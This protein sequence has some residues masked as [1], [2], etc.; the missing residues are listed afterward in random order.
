ML[1]FTKHQWKS[2]LWKA[3]LKVAGSWYISDPYGIG[4]NSSFV[5]HIR[6][7]VMDDMEPE[8]GEKGSRNFCTYGIV[9]YKKTTLKDT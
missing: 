6:K 4:I 7:G 9:H 5:R 3:R 1:S 2:F 8:R